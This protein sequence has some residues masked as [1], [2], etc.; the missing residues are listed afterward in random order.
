MNKDII[1]KIIKLRKSNISMSEIT[2]ELNISRDSVRYYCYKYNL[3]G[4][5]CTNRKLN[6]QKKEPKNYYKEKLD[7][8]TSICL[9]CSVNFETT[10]KSKKYCSIKC[11]NEYNKKNRKDPRAKNR[12]K[13][14]QYCNKEFIDNTKF[15]K[16]KYCSK[17]CHELWMKENPRHTK[18]CPVCGKEY[19][20]NR[21]EQKY[22]SK[23]CTFLNLMVEPNSVCLC[24]GEKFR[25][26]KHHSGKFCSRNCFIKY[27]G[28]NEISK[29]KYKS[30]LTDASSIKRCKKYK[31]KYENIDPLE[32]FERDKWICGICGEKIDKTLNYPDKMSATLDHIIP[33]SK[34]GTHTRENVQASHGVCNFSKG[35]R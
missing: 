22:C 31:V 19:K 24:C 30:N 18:I 21:K 1:D 12:K 26:Q 11:C 14:C 28:I 6:M 32:I 23:E 17:K 2:K 33:L 15:N 10:N 25:K 8:I 35:N 7:I 27:T 9:N 3:G 29:A 13:Q 5:R 34:G 4:V 20:S 16:L